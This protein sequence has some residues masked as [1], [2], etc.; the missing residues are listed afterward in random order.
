[1]AD[2]TAVGSVTNT[3]AVTGDQP[4]PDPDNNTT[5]ETTTVSP[6]PTDADLVVA[7]TDAVDPVTV[8]D[9]VTYTVTVTNDGPVDATGVT[10]TDTLDAATS[11]VSAT[12]DQGSCSETGGTITCDLGAIAAGDSVD[13]T[14]VADPT[15]VGSVTN[16]VAVTGDQPDPDPDNNTTTE[17]TTIAA[18][19]ELADVRIAKTGPAE[20]RTGDTIT[21]TI[22]VDNLG[23]STATDVTI[24]DD[25]PGGVAYVSATT[26]SGAC[27]AVGNRVD[28]D[29]G[30]LGAGASATVEITAVV[31]DEAPATITNTA[32]VSSTVTD[33]DASNNISSADV[34]ITDST[35]S[36]PVTGSDLGGFARIGLA[37]LIFGGLFVLLVRRQRIGTA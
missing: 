18:T 22:Q 9:P 37:L 28:C 27:A 21:Y 26:T 15:A 32:A 19:P 14:I 3:V 7:K 10:V 4:D 20:A 8:G 33:P 1:V 16:T 29:L 31:A 2:T 25:L 24:S 6:P 35:S 13:I 30:D 23:P 12:P 5:T 34:A 17:T 11:Y 36:I